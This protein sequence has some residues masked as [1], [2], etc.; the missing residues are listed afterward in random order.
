VSEVYSVVIPAYN[1]EMTIEACLASV[2]AQTL[3][4]LEVLIIDDHS[5]DRTEAAVQKCRNLFAG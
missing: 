4:P 3:A 5:S 2:I 1:A